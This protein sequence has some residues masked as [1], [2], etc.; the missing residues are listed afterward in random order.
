[1]ATSTQH[2]L[3]IAEVHPRM[4]ARVAGRVSAVTYRP[5][6]RN[7]QLR[8]RLTDASGSL[9]LVFHG[10]R[11]IAGITPGRQLIATGTV[12]E[13]NGDIVIFDPEYRLLPFGSLDL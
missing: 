13:E 7:P 1:M 6:S 2:G 5:E 9:D 11:E 3:P 8:A 4:R 12:Y 10:R